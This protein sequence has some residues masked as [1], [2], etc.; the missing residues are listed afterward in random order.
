MI[1]NRILLIPLVILV[2]GLGVTAVLAAVNSPDEM[3]L[4]QTKYAP[5]INRVKPFPSYSP[6]EDSKPLQVSRRGRIYRV[7]FE[8]NTPLVSLTTDVN[9]AQD[10]IAGDT[11]AYATVLVT[12]TN[13]VDD[14]K[15]VSYIT[16]DDAGY[17]YVGCDDWVSGECPDIA[18]GDM[19]LV[20][21]DTGGMTGTG[22]ID[23]VGT[24]T[25]IFDEVDD[26]I[27]GTLDAD[28][29]AVPLD[30][31]CE[32]E[33]GP[34]I[35]A[36]VNPNGG[37]FPCDF[38]GIWD[39]QLGQYVALRYFEPDGD[40]VINVLEWPKMRVN[41]AQDWVG[42]NYD[43]GHTFLYTLTDNLRV[44]KS[45]GS[46]QTTSRGGWE[47]PGFQSEVWEPELPDIIPG[48][49]IYFTADD[50]YT[51]SIQTG[52]I[53]G[54]TD[55]ENNLVS[56]TINVLGFTDP[57]EVEC[58]PWGAWDAGLGD[59]PIKTS[60]AAPD[61][62]TEF[63][64]QWDPATEWD[65]QL[66]Q[67]VGVMYFELDGDS[68]IDV[69]NQPEV[70]QVEVWLNPFGDSSI[71]GMA[72][73]GPITVTVNSD[74]YYAYA[75]AGCGGCWMI[76]PAGPINPGNTIVVEAGLGELPATINIPDPFEAHVNTD[77]EV[78][79]GQIDHFD[80]IWVEILGNWEDGY[81]LV[82][83]DNDG[84]FSFTY[85]S[86]PRGA[87]GEVIFNDAIN[88]AD[89]II[90]H[91]FQA[92]DLLLEVN[93][94]YDWVGGQYEPGHTV[95]LT[96]TQSD[97]T[98]V[99]G[100]AEL[101]TFEIPGWE[102]DT[103]FSSDSPG[104]NGD[105]KPDLLP[106]DWVFGRVDNGYT[107]DVHIGEITGSV[108]YDNDFVS[109]SIEATWF[110]GEVDFLEVECHPWGAWDTGIDAPIKYSTASPN[111]ADPYF[112]QWDPDTE[113]D[114]QPNQNLAVIYLEPDGDKVI[115]VFSTGEI[116]YLPLV[117]K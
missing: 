8:P 53:F 38:D 101:T 15:G 54:A 82:Q 104:W 87:R 110:A 31:A 112:C 55:I 25:G 98:T 26:F 58:H 50:G 24:I 59:V 3:E 43:I 29:F 4:P 52:E 80:G 70:R 9:Y 83:T 64:C 84:Y 16:S 34:T 108:D 1:R 39:L 21:V 48:D 20:I 85:S 45:S 75:D 11:D 63:M 19:V 40:S 78:V 61:G 74:Q 17:Y 88:Y 18:P 6:R 73:N 12:V 93:Y 81:Q 115:R 105:N 102:G 35:T 77:T 66:G 100:L 69:Y 65:M 96:A 71:G 113:W 2:A 5:E 90:H 22:T 89:V 94:T 47:G 60:S 36:T 27:T 41:Y 97:S 42:G 10:W 117:S 67:R 107:T 46:A 49:W 68:I 86:I 109:G 37:S 111:S 91:P 72:V 103:G 14:I 23:P 116:V 56:G 76:D 79:Y 44:V 95:W 106:Y 7:G 32:V 30:V 114:M 99:K 13:S 57:L 51:K 92:L 62:T 33:G 28:W